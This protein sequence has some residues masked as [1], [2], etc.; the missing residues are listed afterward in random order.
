[1]IFSFYYCWIGKTIQAF[2]IKRHIFGDL[3]NQFFKIYR[4][5][6]LKYFRAGKAEISQLGFISGD[7]FQLYFDDRSCLKSGEGNNFQFVILIFRSF[8]RDILGECVYGLFFNWKGDAIGF[9]GSCFDYFNRFCCFI[10]TELQISEL[11]YTR[12]GI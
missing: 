1:M 12:A 5:R 8:L 11:S 9:K 3:Y 10:I 4:N 6:R 7:L 2:E